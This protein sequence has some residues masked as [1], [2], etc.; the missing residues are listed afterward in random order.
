[1]KISDPLDPVPDFSDTYDRLMR[2]LEFVHKGIEKDRTF[3]ELRDYVSGRLLS[4]STANQFGQ[5][6]AYGRKKTRRICQ[7][8]ESSVAY[9]GEAA[10]AYEVGNIA[11]AWPRMTFAY[12]FL[13]MATITEHSVRSAFASAEPHEHY[14]RHIVELLEKKHP[15]E[16]WIDRKAAVAAILPDFLVFY[17]Q[18]PPDIQAV[19]EHPE[20]SLDDWSKKALKLQFL[21]FA[22][23]TKP[24]RPK[25]SVN[26]KPSSK[27]KK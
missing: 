18:Q 23:E 26:S 1:M 21:K 8:I 15:P 27:S 25:G 13:G 16:L 17:K 24:G 6:Y 11:A 2:V 3:D 20:V 5:D 7:L 22:H 9:A 4:G 19:L 14:K 10:D 12:Y